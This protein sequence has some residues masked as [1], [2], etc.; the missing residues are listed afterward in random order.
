MMRK[1]VPKNKLPRLC[2][3]KCYFDNF[4]F[5]FTTVGKMLILIIINDM[6]WLL[7]RFVYF[8]YR[9]VI[10]QFQLFL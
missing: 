7:R 8:A 5:L 3:G 4:L 1:H 2:H 6:H 10:I 9:F